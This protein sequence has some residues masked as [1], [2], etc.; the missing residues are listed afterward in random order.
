[1]IN[2]KT[3]QTLHSFDVI[4]FLRIVQWN[5]RRHI[6]FMA[7][8]ISTSADGWYYL[9]VPALV[10]LVSAQLGLVM[11]AALVVGFAIERPSY[12]V[13]KNGFKRHRPPNI[14]PGFESV[15]TASDEFSFPSG[16]TSGA[17]L[18]VTT[19]MLLMPLGV[20]GCYLYLWATAV[21]LSRIM[22]GVHFPLDTVAG[23]LLGSSI[24]WCAVQLVTIQ[25]PTL[26]SAG[27][28]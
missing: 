10:A 9:L 7:N 22:L 12:F 3:L 17:F 20:F 15:I 14:I 27:P 4:A 19:L 23:A 26:L 21:A 18:V 2:I 16:H 6:R 11:L 25:F 28:L 5:T 13:L 1:M 24:A 8:L